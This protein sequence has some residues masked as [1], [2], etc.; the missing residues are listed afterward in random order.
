[1]AGY[2]G[3]PLAKKIGIKEGAHVLVPHDIEWYRALLGD[4]PSGVHFANTEEQERLYDIIHVFVC[5][6]EE[7]RHGVTRYRE[8]LQKNGALWVSWR[9][10]KIAKE[11]GL[12][13]DAVRGMALEVGLVDVKVAAVDDVWSALKLVYRK[14]DRL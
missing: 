10:G 5:S 1:M 12:N 9:K 4:I 8:V 11:T 13:E 14:K 6:H 7:L 3:T 2:S